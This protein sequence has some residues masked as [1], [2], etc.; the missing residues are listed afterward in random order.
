MAES[1][2]RAAGA[3]S[4]STCSAT[5]TRGAPARGGRPSATRRRCA[6]DPA[7][8]RAALAGAARRRRACSAGSPAAAS[9][10]RRNCSTRAAARLPLLGMRDRRGRARVRD[11]RQFFAALDRLGLPHPPVLLRTRRP[12]PRGW[13][14]KRAGGTRRLAHPRRG[15]RGARA[16][17]APTTSASSPGVP[18]SALFVGR[19]RGSGLI[20]LQPPH[21]AADR[22]ASARLPR[23]DRAGARRVARRRRLEAALAAL[24]PTFGLRGLAS[25][26]FI[27]LDGTPWLLELNPRPSASMALHAQAWPAG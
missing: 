23:R 17:R 12:T 7:A 4:R 24:V 22:R 15:G 19:R 10:A 3:W 8:L 13:L 2:R 9:R 1:A 25:L 6:I 21:R 14:A 20:A 11:P 26:D 18:M 27:A 16:P 5:S